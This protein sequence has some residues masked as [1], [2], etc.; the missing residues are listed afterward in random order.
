MCGIAGIIESRDKRVAPSGLEKLRQALAHRG[1]DGS[2]VWLSPRGDAGLVHTRLAIVDLSET[3]AQ[4]MSSPDGRFHI[5]FNGEIYNHPELRVELEAA[6]HRLR[7]RSDTEVLLALFVRLGE[8]CLD[9]LDGMFAF[10]VYDSHEH[11]LFCARDPLGEKPLYV[12][13]RPGSFAFASEVRALVCSGAASGALDVRGIGLLLRQGS[14]P[15]PFTHVEGVQAVR[16][17]SWLR[18]GPRSFAGE[19]RRYWQLPFVPE[20]AAVRDPREALNL[21]GEALRESVRRR[22]RSDVPVAAFLS[23]GLDSSAVCALMV[24][25]ATAPLQTFTVTQPGQPGDEARFAQEVAA[26]LGVRHTEVPLDLD[27]S[28]HWLD[29]ALDAMDVPSCDGPNTWLVSR[30][31]SEAGIKAACSGVGGDELFL[32][33]SS[34]RTLPRLLKLTR[35]LR[36]LV[37]ARSLTAR[38]APWLPAPPPLGRVVDASLGGADLAALYLAKRGLFSAHEVREALTE[39]AWS[40]ASSVDPIARIAALPIP[41]GLSS[42]R[43]V[44][45][46]ELTV[47]MHDQLLRDTDTM[48]MAHA[49]EVRLPL[50]SP[51]VVAAVGSL[52]AEVLDGRRPKLLLH[53]VVAPLLPRG[54]FDRPKQGFTLGWRSILLSRERDS[55]GLPG[56]FRPRVYAKERARLAHGK[57]GFA[58]TFVLGALAHAIERQRLHLPRPF[59]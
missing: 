34:F 1:P 9:R 3:G 22:L 7:G 42:V 8:R 46:H 41:P 11:S 25:Q 21:V 23:G 33:Y 30:A 40:V 18:V 12:A 20:R 32:G 5:T 55:A 43:S 16:P 27:D 29:Q 28:G 38:L 4:P 6:G 44:S 49:L 45:C 14:I 39:A 17:G 2:G 53:E 15:P 52:S 31:V 56:L 48:S 10:A 37:R 36:P 57:V 58:R 24:E 35:P 26:H 13:R 59:G 50:I 47:Y 19:E 51:R 54:L